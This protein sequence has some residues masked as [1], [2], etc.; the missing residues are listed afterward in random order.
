MYFDLLIFII[1]KEHFQSHRHNLDQF[2]AKEKDDPAANPNGYL[3]PL[4][5][6][7]FLLLLSCTSF[8]LH[9][10]MPLLLSLLSFS[11]YRSD[12]ERRDAC[13]CV[14]RVSRQCGAD[15]QH[16]ECAVQW[17]HQSARLHRTG[18]R[19]GSRRYFLSIYFNIYIS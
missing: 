4:F 10:M 11:R 3:L 8:P 15:C 13:D 5:S 6:F 1:L 19:Q 16:A 7:F 12:Q 17:T 18:N 9:C 14:H 2:L